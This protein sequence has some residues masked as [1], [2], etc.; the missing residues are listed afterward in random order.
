MVRCL[1][2]VWIAC[3]AAAGLK[4]EAE[5]R[6]ASGLIVLYDFEE[7]AGTTIR[8]RSLAAPLLDLRI[9]TPRAV[10]WKPRAIAIDGSGMIATVAPAKKIVDAVRKTGAISIEVW[11]KPAS[12]A[13]N[14]PARIVSLSADPGHRNFTLGQDSTRYDVRVRTEKTGENGVP[15]LATPENVLT[16]ALTPVVYTRDSAGKGTTWRSEI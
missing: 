12:A 1:T 3:L 15:S 9:D 14:G 4:V 13:Q 16:A 6:V 7:G 8:D 2:F 10:R 5:D 11:V